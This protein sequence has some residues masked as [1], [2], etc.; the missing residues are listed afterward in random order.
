MMKSLKKN[1]SFPIFQRCSD[2]CKDEFWK[3]QLRDMSTGR[4]PKNIL[5]INKTLTSSGKK[6]ASLSLENIKEEELAPLIVEFLQQNC[7]IFSAND[8]KKK[9]I[10]INQIKKS[11]DE[12]KK[13]KWP[14]IRKLNVRKLILLDFV[15]KSKMEY[16]LSWGQATSLYKQCEEIICSKGHSRKINFEDGEII[17]IDGVTLKSGSFEVQKLND[18][19]KNIKIAKRDSKWESFIKDHLKEIYNSLN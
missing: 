10:L 14:Q 4:M 19:G 5:I 3:Q 18:L 11:N 9:C 6:S 16:K 13:L 12:N 15:Y 1:I 2:H 8:I 7:S 17:S